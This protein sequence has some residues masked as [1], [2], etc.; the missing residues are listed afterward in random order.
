MINQKKTKS[1]AMEEIWNKRTWAR[2]QKTF[3][4]TWFVVFHVS[5][6]YIWIIRLNINHHINHQKRNSYSQRSLPFQNIFWSFLRLNSYIECKNDIHTI[7]SKNYLF[8][9]NFCS[10]FLEFFVRFSFLTDSYAIIFL[11]LGISFYNLLN[12]INTIRL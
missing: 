3:L 11:T 2:K 6:F 10:L 12:L 7:E 5:I 9:S 1:L 4:R 8:K